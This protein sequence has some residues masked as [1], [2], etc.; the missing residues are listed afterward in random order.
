MRN[1]GNGM[2]A[3][4]APATIPWPH[5]EEGT[6]PS[7]PEQLAGRIGDRILAGEFEPGARII[8]QN[9][10]QEYG[11]SR[12]P[13]RDAFRILERERLLTNNPR[14][15]VT[16]TLLTQKDLAE[17][18]EINSALLG[19]VGRKLA[20]ARSKEAVQLLNRAIEEVRAWATNPNVAGIL[21]AVGYRLT[22]DLVQLAGNARMVRIVANQS[23]E[24]YRYRLLAF[25]SEVHRKKT[26]ARWRALQ[27]AI[28]QGNVSAAVEWWTLVIAATR[29]ELRGKVPDSPK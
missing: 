16:V 28:K 6:I 3:T 22:I 12:G 26:L 29:N 7:L 18:F 15:G 27:R 4:E 25:Q 11:V 8:E 23:L 9:L 17:I 19:I 21:A 20:E 1:I 13:I 5:S 2:P 14:R 10:A 24:S